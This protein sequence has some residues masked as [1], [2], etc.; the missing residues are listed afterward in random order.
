MKHFRSVNYD[1]R[2]PEVVGRYNLNL[3]LSEG[4]VANLM[5]KVNVAKAGSWDNTPKELFCI[6]G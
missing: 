6:R 4:S 2:E 5:K 3:S 1:P